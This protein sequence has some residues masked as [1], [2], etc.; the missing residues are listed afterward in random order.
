MFAHGRN[1]VDNISLRRRFFEMRR[2]IFVKTVWSPQRKFSLE[3]PAGTPSILMRNL[4]DLE[5]RSLGEDSPLREKDA[6]DAPFAVDTAFFP[7]RCRGEFLEGRLFLCSRLLWEA[8][9]LFVHFLRELSE[10]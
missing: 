8:L 6:L 1:F 4:W 5:R 10:K 7:Q 2:M 3:Y 9:F